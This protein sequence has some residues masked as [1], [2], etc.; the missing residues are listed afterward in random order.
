MRGAYHGA[1]RVVGN[2]CCW[3]R[4]PPLS[5][6]TTVGLWVAGCIAL[7]FPCVARAQPSPPQSSTS[8]PVAPVEVVVHGTKRAEDIGVEDVRGR[9]TRSV[10]G[11]FGDPFQAVA[12]LPGVAPTASGLPYFYVRGA[13][14]ANTGY[15]LDGI[16]LP[17]LFH[18]GPG[19]SVVPQALV[20]RIEFFPSTAPAA[21]GRF[22]GGV[23]AA[24][25]TAPRPIARGE[26]SVRLF[27]ASAFV[28]SP[29]GA[30]NTALVAG[31]IGYPNLLLS[32][33]A[34]ELSLGYGDY[35]ARVTHALTD[36][37]TISLFAI[38]AYDRE[39]DRTHNLLPF[40]SQFHRADLRYDHRWV[41]GSVR[42]AATAGYDRTSRELS[43]PTRETVVATGGRLRFALQQ[44]LGTAARLSAGADANATHYMSAFSGPSPETLPMAAEQVGGAYV[45][46]KL[47]PA[48]RVELAVGARIDA[49]RSAGTITAS[50][51]PKLASRI[52]LGDDVAWTSTLSVAHQE[53]TRVVP[54]P[55]LRLDASAGLQTTYQFAEGV[56]A[57]LPSSVKAGLTAFYSAHRNLSDFV[58][59]CG[60]LAENCNEVARV[61]GRTY[62]LEVL[63]QRA[64][65]QRF[66][67]WLSYT[68]SRAERRIGRTTYLSPFDRPNVFSA[69]LSYDFG[70]GVRV[71]ARGTYYSGRPDIPTLAVSGQST[72]F[73]FG[74]GQPLAQHRLPAFYRIDVRAEK[75]WE[76]G[77]NGAWLAAVF[78]FFDATLSKEAIDFQ[79]DV[80][81]TAAGSGGGLCQAQYLGP[82][83]LPSVGVEGGF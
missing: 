28:E 2:Q 65:T 82:I 48:R 80:S 75:R 69:V 11:T 12:T 60:T 72:R 55:G 64:I 31:R 46:L 37:D 76:L 44:R 41:G 33:F 20:D 43:T 21:F 54:V 56:E 59:T 42:V 74:P 38:G 9:D 8:D 73:A 16:P 19:P 3:G 83:A 18:I 6:A 47:R 63:V 34:P 45:D 62:G 30:S 79:C 27:D 36:A 70:V 23:I 52:E 32:I 71:G 7:P 24:S 66:A 49:Y 25:T 50:F 39:E 77:P 35:T 26:G 10:P 15:F 1:R 4:L 14:P 40:D 68:L 13:P 81:S 5:P 58:A 57:K 51:D 22:A 17:T 67:G 78:E 53:P 61:D 29:I